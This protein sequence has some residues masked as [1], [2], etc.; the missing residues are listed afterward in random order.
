MRILFSTN[1]AL[2]HVL[3]LL[4]LALAA[5]GAGHDVAV[6]G[7]QSVAGIVE[8]AGLRHVVGG[9]PDLP[10]VFARVPERQ[11]LSGRRLAAATWAHAFGGVIAEALAGALLDLAREWRPDLVVHDD[12]EQGTWIA[13]ERLGIPHVSLQATAWRGAGVRLSAEPLN[14]LRTSLGLPPDP[15]LAGWHRHGYLT[16]RPPALFNPDDPMPAATIPVRPI[17]LDGV[18]AEMPAW[19]DGSRAGR[20][21]VAVTLGTILPGRLEAMASILDGLARLDVEVVATVGPGLD[22]AELGPRPAGV[23]VERYLPMSR[24]LPT[25]DALVFHGG[26]GTMLAALADGLPLVLL[27]SQADQPENADRCEAAGVGIALPP[28]AQ[29][30]DDVERAVDAVLS[31]PGYRDAA[32]RVRAEIEGM[33]G[34]ADVLPA[35]E[36]LAA[37]GPVATLID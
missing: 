21:R 6:L 2:G 9:P 32:A 8:G 5:R 19:L 18:G 12:S 33:P 13:A 31:N 14:R 16:T 3:P 22:P 17:A 30:A 36:R 10:S 37:A 34:P 11:G 26:S 7:G 25:C 29:Q 28:G 15:A 4:P 35:L 20:A 27:P 24:L 23:R 1:P